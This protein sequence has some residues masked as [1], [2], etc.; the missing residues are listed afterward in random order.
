MK[1]VEI[2]Q[3]CQESEDVTK[4]W[5]NGSKIWVAKSKFTSEN[6]HTHLEESLLILVLVVI[7][8]TWVFLWILFNMNFNA[9][10][11][12]VSSILNTNTIISVKSFLCSPL[13]TCPPYTLNYRAILPGVYLLRFEQSE[14]EPQSLSVHVDTYLPVPRFEGAIFSPVYIFGMFVKNF[15]VVVWVCF[16][17]SVVWWVVSVESLET[18]VWMYNLK[19]SLVIAPTLSMLLRIALTV[20]GLLCLHIRFWITF[21]FCISVRKGDRILL[22]IPW[23]L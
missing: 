20:W 5:S 1:A 16:V 4:P 19:L 11:A 21:F 2:F 8:Y 3:Q 23:D 22:G 9:L 10:L 6:Y 17:L 18:W 7:C 15:R 13:W 14:M 12:Q